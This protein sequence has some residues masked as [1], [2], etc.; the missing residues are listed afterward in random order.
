ME[1]ELRKEVDVAAPAVGVWRAWTTTD[2]VVAFFAPEALIEPREGGAFELYFMTE[3]PAGSRGS[4]GCRFVELEPPRRF[5]VSWNFPPSLP[6]IRDEQTRVEIALEPRGDH[7]TRVRLLQTGWR[8]GDDWDKGFA[9][10]DRAWGF[11]LARLA[12]SFEHGPIDW[13]DPWVPDGL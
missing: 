12:R 5:V 6:A 4:E 13:S 8:E 7:A 9:Y 1:R 11:V 2:G 10:F 3:A